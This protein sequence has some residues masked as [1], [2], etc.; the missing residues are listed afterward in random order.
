[1]RK[2]TILSLL[3]IIVLTS[4]RYVGERVRGNGNLKTE[5]RSAA[6]FT[7]VSSFGEYDV[8]L[9]QGTSYSVRIE[10]EENLLP[11]IETIVDG[12]MLKIR[13]KEGYWL[14]NSTD[15]KIFVSAP[16]Y[17]K[18][19]T[20]GS[21][22]ILSQGKL[23]NTSAIELEVAGSGDVKVEV[24]APEVRADLQGSGNIDLSG[25]TRTFTGSILGSGDIKAANLKSENANVDIT[26]S[27]NADVY[28]SVKL[29]VDIKG[30]GDVR[31][32]GSAQ[33]SSNVAGSGSVKKVD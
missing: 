32:R 15:L 19:K 26:G 11:Y 17:S 14:S 28:A 2:I 9:S 3:A 5:D 20:F 24:N 10:A 22:N 29:D 25:E 8:Y 27:G 13:T 18:V 6:N 7:S 30:S 23:N 21:G 4:C 33:T 12:D 1:M 31:Y 16:A